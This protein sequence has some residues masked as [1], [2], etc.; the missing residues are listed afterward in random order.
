MISMEQARELVADSALWPR[1]RSFLWDFAPQVH[2]S[3]LSDD[4]KTALA[5]FPDSQRVKGAALSS[6]GVAPAFHDFPVED[7]S[8]ICLL[9]SATLVSIVHWLGA[10]KFLPV[11]RRTADGATVRALKAA[12][13][14][15][16]PA[17]MSFAA[18][19]RV[20]AEDAS[21][22]SGT[23]D[24]L[25]SLIVPAGRTCLAALLSDVP[26]PV[27]QRLR[28]KLPK[29]LDATEENAADEVPAFNPANFKTLLKLKFP[30]ACELCC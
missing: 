2:P 28:L 25:A 17:V 15:A 1:V 30:E 22:P 10:I 8:R 9:D 18:Y 27:L 20:A 21:A 12:I 23:P 5:R 4:L 26:P 16:Y 3:W 19:F 13:P 29:E 6:L 7:R 11:L 24:N 14:D